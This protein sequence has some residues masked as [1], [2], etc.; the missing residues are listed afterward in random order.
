MLST[1]V[2]IQDLEVTFR[3][4]QTTTT[5]VNQI[6]LSIGKGEIVGVVGE[7]GSGKS[8]TA[9]SLMR[10]IDMP[11]TISGG[12]ILYQA[13]DETAVNLL[14]LPDATMRSYRGNEIA[15]IFQEPMT[16]LN[17]LHTCGEQ[18]AEAIRL[19]TGVSRKAARNEVIALFEKVKLPDPAGI[20][21]R[22][23][24]EISGGQK[25]RVMIAMAISCHP[26][27]LIAD[28][29]T[30]ALDV[31]V[32]KAILELLRELQQQME[33]S[34]IFITHDLGVVAEIAERVVVMYKGNI[35]EEGTVRNVFLHP[36]HPYTKGLLACRPPLDKRLVRLPVIRDF[37]ETDSRG[38]I[39]EKAGAIREV[40]QSLVIPEA[41]LRQ[42]ELQL[43]AA[44]PLLEVHELKTWF[45]VK[46]SITG[47]VLQWAKAVDDVSFR[48]ITG[49]TLGL[50]GESGCGKTTLGRS[51]LR[52]AEPT[53][54]SIIYK[55]QD[56]RSLSA[57]GMR[58]LRKDMQLIFQDPYASLNP[59]KTIG[60]AILE[61]MKVHGLYG[62]ERQQKAKVLEL[63]EK[64]NLLPEHFNRYP[65]EFSGGQRQRIVIARALAVE[66]SFIICDESV[67]ALDV[68]VQAQVLN[69]LI[70]LREELGF[71]CIF[72]SHDLSVVRFISD[73]MMVMQKGKIVEQGAADRVYNHPE[74][75]YTQQ[76]IAAIPKGI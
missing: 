28:E 18:V 62:T 70:R 29:P 19:H 57:G 14:Q 24:H 4:G 41:T 30:T 3:S 27:L 31:T 69:L 71:T 72:I 46:R 56:I 15:M 23:P 26:R 43:A 2:E 13:A 67:A 32:Q 51:L 74:N 58:A 49:E 55:G 47:K 10:L 76:L 35:V 38:Q 39:H 21:D 8:V 59:R 53:A 9:L 42:R 50:V 37:M 61:P 1:R 44:A 63:L 20:M 7:S 65:H 11:G 40:M 54:G 45:P 64:V 6:F 52:L 36:Q 25:Q 75:P 12:Q 16:A 33:M 60:A 22:Y 17:P 73:R 34:V 66:P 68:S 48:V 5:A